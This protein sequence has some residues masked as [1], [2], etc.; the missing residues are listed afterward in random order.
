MPFRPV[1]QLMF[2]SFAR[3]VRKR[4]T[5][6]TLDGITY[7]LD[8]GELC[9]LCIYLQHYEPEVVA[10]MNRYTRPGMTVVD[11]GA[12]IGAHAL[13]FARLTGPAGKVVAFEPTDFAYAKLTRNVSLN[14]MPQVTT[15]KLALSDAT[16]EPQ[17][18]DLRS[19]WRTDNS[20]NDGMSSVG[21]DRL[22]AWAERNGLGRID[23]IKVDVEGNE[24]PLIVGAY[25][26]IK[27]DLPV[28]LMEVVGLHLDD[29]RRNPFLVLERL[30]YRFEDLRSGAPI[31]IEEMRARTPRNDVGISTSFNI[32]AL[33]P[34]VP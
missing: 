33:P 6:A 26:T 21:F 30:G 13:R 12:N 2:D 10:A 9:D 15:V 29:D 11:I 34:A 18:I 17:H 27:R 14:D 22:D 32:I 20:R 8:L 1:R 23:V 31:T 25:E 4:R 16:H 7:D 5:V 19:S 28:M 3:L 24:F